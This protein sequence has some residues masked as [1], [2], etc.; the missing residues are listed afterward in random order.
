MAFFEVRS[1]SNP[2]FSMANVLY[3]LGGLIVIGA[4]TFYATTAWEELGG[5]GHL[6]VAVAYG[7]AFL[8]AGNWLWHGKG[9]AHPRRYPGHGLRSA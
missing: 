8:L 3:Y 9:Q 2:S 1:E 6:I 7:L 4:M 5:L